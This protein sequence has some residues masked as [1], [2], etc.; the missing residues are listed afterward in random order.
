MECH[1]NG[2]MVSY[3]KE[4]NGS[5]LILLHGWGSNKETFRGIIDH[6]SDEYCCFSIDL[7]GFGESPIEHS[8]SLD[9][10][11][12][13]LEDFIKI[14]GIEKPI[15]LG[16]S[17]GGRIAISFASN[18]DV[19]KLIL[20]DS[21]GVRKFNLK[22]FLKIKV[23]KFMKLLG[24]KKNIGSSDYR[25]ASDVL[26]QTM[27]KI[28]PIDLT[29][30]LELIDAETLILWGELDETTKLS[31]GKL[32]S[33]LIRNSALIVIPKAKHFPYLE[34]PRYFMLMLMAFLA[35]DRQ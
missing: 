1:I 19:S 9:D 11:V 27:N 26:K 7:P 2:L 16:H 15:I 33:K 25:N 29:N 23:Y 22:V 17:F 6:L 8:M 18:H 5:P 35:S 34:H 30:R 21:A 24:I 20:V 14:N 10:Y 3:L 12:C 28:V 13:V 4:G 32:M 31:D